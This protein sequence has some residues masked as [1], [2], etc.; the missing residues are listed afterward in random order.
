M[1][2]RGLIAAPSVTSDVLD[3]LKLSTEQETENREDCGAAITTVESDASNVSQ[4][5]VAV[6][7]ACHSLF[8]D[9]RNKSITGELSLC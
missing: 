5:S 8:R 6:M 9:P 7:G 4:L 3:L 2:F 1:L